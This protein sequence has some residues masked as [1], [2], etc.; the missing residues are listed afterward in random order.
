MVLEAPLTLPLIPLPSQMS[1]GDGSF[2]LPDTL[3][4]AIPDSLD[5]EGKRL[6]EALRETAH[7]KL[8]N[9]REI[10]R[11]QSGLTMKLDPS[12][13][14]FGDEGYALD[15]D[16]E[17]IRIVA[18]KPA[19]AFYAVQT[20]RQ[21][22]LRR[23]TAP[24]AVPEVH[25]VDEPRFGWRGMLL[26]VSRHFFTVAEIKKCLDY[27]SAMKMNI[28]HWH[29]TDDGG[30][31]MEV[32]KYPQLTDKGAWRTDFPGLVW[33]YTQLEFPGKNAGKE[34]YGGFYTQDEI[35]E[36]VRYAADRHIT[37][38]PEIEM[39]G[40]A[41]AAMES[42]P[43]LGCRIE[44]RPGD[45]YRTNV[46]C[47]GKESTM[48]FLRD[49]LDETMELFPSKI[50]HIGGDEVDKGYW[51]RCPDCSAY[52]KANGLRDYHE[53]QSSFIKRAETYL[54]SKGRTLLGWDEILEGGLAP[55]AM[56]MSWRGEDGGIA[57]AKSGHDVVMSPTS[58]CYFDYSYDAISTQHAYSYE[59]VP[60][61]LTPEGGK[62]VR[63]G[64]ANVWTEWIA[65]FDRVE[66]M[67]FPRIFAM[68]EVL[69]TPKA[70]KYFP[71]F[72]RR[73][74]EHYA[75][76]VR[77]GIDFYVGR[78][79]FDANLIVFEKACT[80]N[81]DGPSLPGVAL[82]YTMDGKTPTG[83]S[84]ALSGPLTID[85]SAV[86]TA[87]YMKGGKVLE[88][89]AQV[90]VIKGVP[91]LKP[92]PGIRF[93]M[94]KKAFQKMPDWGK[95]AFDQEGTANT[96]D[97][98]PFVSNEAFGV[99]WNGY[100][101]IQ[102]EGLYTFN[103]GSD[104]GSVLRICNATV[105]DHDGAHAFTTKSGKAYLLPGVYPFEIGYFESGGAERFEATVEGPGMGIRPLSDI[106]LKR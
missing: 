13:S 15:V 49:V 43:E 86:V 32:K 45:P 76:L 72:E 88:A 20:L 29:L 57:A 67:I 27:L 94:V 51:S 99:V 58:H 31:R 37:I 102:K 22:L 19:G 48:Q 77:Q 81:L 104:D 60:A 66:T 95:V 40:H 92:L 1:E 41:L 74:N 8:Q 38:I 14:R 42:Y 100:L 50:I 85:R 10:R 63:G 78:P 90:T 4:A 106:A 87:A 59:P 24:F 9:V 97:I 47:A 80:V 79:Q 5:N 11:G 54:N 82:R 23:G 73:L 83:N 105:V 56:V 30:W 71:H 55:N 84:S 62:R 26:D 28:F 16:Q 2:R 46:F 64:Q 98:A 93:A 35:R 12:D 21:M 3:A 53:L 18:R 36:V 70:K 91:Q 17:R 101:Q 89:P 25:I 69:W 44:L 96:L 75:E 65:D 103:L 61:A 6:G 7:V 68:A 33:S 39:P 52:M 34:L